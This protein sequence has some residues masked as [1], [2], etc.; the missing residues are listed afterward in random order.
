MKMGFEVIENT[1]KE[2]AEKGMNYIKRTLKEEYN[3]TL[4]EIHLLA[5]AKAEGRIIVL[6][7]A[8]GNETYRL[9]DGEIESDTLVSYRAILNPET[10]EMEEFMGF[11]YYDQ[12][13]YG[14]GS[15]CIFEVKKD[16]FDETWFVDHE[17]AVKICAEEKG[18]E[19]QPDD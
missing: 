4:E 14:E 13:F 17:K 8:L 15:T 16:I 9:I 3:T 11:K 1:A 19:G 10:K 12:P 7:C 6:P 2:V 18:A 5:K